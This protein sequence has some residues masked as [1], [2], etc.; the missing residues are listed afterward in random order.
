MSIFDLTPPQDNTSAEMSRATNKIYTQIQ[1]LDSRQK[2]T[3]NRAYLKHILGVNE[4]TIESF[5]GGDKDAERIIGM[6][7]IGKSELKSDT[8]LFWQ[9]FC[10]IRPCIYSE[11]E[12]DWLRKNFVHT[13]TIY[14]IVAMTLTHSIVSLSLNNCAQSSIAEKIYEATRKYAKKFETRP[15]L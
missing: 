8:Y 3:I 10:N 5:I 15:N 7:Q 1:K 14:T 2:D 12:K 11:E 13:K 6:K 4:Q 9:E